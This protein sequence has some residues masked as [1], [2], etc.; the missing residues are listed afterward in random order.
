VCVRACVACVVCGGR[1]VCV[2]TYYSSSKKGLGFG[3]QGLGS[4]VLGAPQ[5]Q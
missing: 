4:R 2:C 5:H 3:V 1:C